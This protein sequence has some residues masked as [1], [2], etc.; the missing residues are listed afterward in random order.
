MTNWPPFA[1]LTVAKY[2]L[3][4][5]I[6]IG[7]ADVHCKDLTVGTATTAGVCV[8]DVCARWVLVS[9]SGLA[10]HWLSVLVRIVG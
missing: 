5:S 4:V 1:I 6:V 7:G 3:V 10:L 2:C 9:Q 8:L